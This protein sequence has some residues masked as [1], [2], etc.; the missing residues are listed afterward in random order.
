MTVLR[1]VDL[2]VVSPDETPALL[3]AALW[4]ATTLTD[5]PISKLLDLT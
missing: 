2:S 3:G 5:P 4:P 1:T